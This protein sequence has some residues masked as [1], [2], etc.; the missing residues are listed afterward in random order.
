M[1]FPIY[2]QDLQPQAA[3]KK[4][5]RSLKNRWLGQ[6]PIQQTLANEILSKGLGYLGYYEVRS[7][8]LTCPPE[9]PTPSE[10]DVCASIAAEIF[11]FLKQSNDNSVQRIALERFV[12]SLP[13]KALTA[14][15]RAGVHETPVVA[16]NQ[17]KLDL[18]SGHTCF[19]NDICPATPIPKYLCPAPV[20]DPVLTKWTKRS[21][22]PTKPVNPTPQSDLD[23]IKKAV[24]SSGNLRHQSL[25]AL[26]EAGIRWN[27]I[28]GAKV[29]QDL[30]FDT[31]PPISLVINKS[32][33]PLPVPD[34]AVVR[35]YI[36]SEGLMPGDYLFPSKNE[37]TQPMR[38]SELL[39][40]WRSW[41]SAAGLPSGNLTPT[42]IRMA[43]THP[44]PRSAIDLSEMKVIPTELGYDTEAMSEHYT[45]E[46]DAKGV[47]FIRKDNA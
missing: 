31:S 20:P 19:V 13:L 27:E 6:S 16:A 3:F 42:N 15:K 46:F 40:T 12:E 1:R 47:H 25:L 23:A 33:M 38:E 28:A 5:A 17:S 36:A 26:F 14:F 39:N 41:K 24:E 10:S 8:S 35:R 34:V 43:F 30:H 32:K 4:L 37:R 18:T 7:S 9:M 44:N 21:R 22:L 11:L 2:P 45:V 29:L